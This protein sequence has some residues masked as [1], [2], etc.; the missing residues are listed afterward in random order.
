V[1]RGGSTD[2]LL[3]RTPGQIAVDGGLAVSRF[4]LSTCFPRKELSP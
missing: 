2:R 4:S 1:L 3:A